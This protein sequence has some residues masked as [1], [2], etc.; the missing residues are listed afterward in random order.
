[1]IF[2]AKEK[3]EAIEREIAMRKRVY[4]RWVAAGRMTPAKAQHETEVMEEIAA[5]LRRVEEKERLI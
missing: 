1:M 3:R 2:T 4:P 5:D